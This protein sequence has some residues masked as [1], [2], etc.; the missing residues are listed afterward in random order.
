M[1]PTELDRFRVLAQPRLHPTDDFVVF[2]VTRM[3]LEKDRYD[4]S[5][6]AVDSGDVR[7]LAGIRDV[8]SPEWSPDGSTLALLKKVPDDPDAKGDDADKHDQLA[9]VDDP[10][11]PGAVRIL[12]RFPLG[13]SK[14]AWAPAGDRI[15]VV[16]GEY[17]EGW[18]A[19]ESKER[20]K[21]PRRITFVPWR[22]DGGTPWDDRRPVVAL[23]DPSGQREPRRMDAG[24]LVSVE[25]VAWH[26]GNGR[27]AILADRVHESRTRLEQV[28]LEVDSGSGAVT[29]RHRDGSWYEVHYVGPRLVVIGLP[30]LNAWPAPTALYEI[31]ESGDPVAL[32][33]GHDRM[34]ASGRVA[35][36]T[37][38]FLHDDQGRSLAARWDGKGIETFDDDVPFVSDFDAR[39]D[40]ERVI[41]ARTPTDPGE[42]VRVRDGRTDR[43][44][45]LNEDFPGSTT[46]AAPEHFVVDTGGAEVD[47]WV[48][49]PEGKER[50]PVLL[51]IHGGPATQYGFGFF[52]EFQVYAGAGY[53]VVACNPRGSSGR[54]RDHLRGVRAEAWGEADQEDVL[55]CLDAALERFDRLDP[56]RV[57]VMGGSYGGF[58]SAWLIGRTDR[59]RSAVVE[60]ALVDWVTFSGNSDIATIF[61]PMYFDDPSPEFLASKSPQGLVKS[62]KTPVLIIHSE[63]DWR[64]PIDQAERY[65][66]ALLAGGVTAEFLR[67][68]G[69]GHELSRSGDPKHR[70]A[71]FEAILDWHGRF[72]KS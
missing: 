8:R 6:W 32:V 2:T 63:Q 39:D 37:L 57:G 1:K 53:G 47:T 21:R 13:V 25:G 61:A 46:L 19:V 51:N 50:V 12:T 67:F 7:E 26:P 42:L 4:S 36:D 43:L 20:P 49:L 5:L 29:E 22:I 17:R 71:R 68:P 31:P 64:C 9:I 23:V 48:Y 69:E 40:G 59:F 24:D 30:E 35:G 56:E 60:R 72:L 65:F 45:R 52:D 58:L 66:H 54:G 33:P 62:V 14:L 16:A 3:N 28:L 44:T 38:H 27:F 34:S 18:D 41:V 55:A 11:G 10:Q 15:L 70:R